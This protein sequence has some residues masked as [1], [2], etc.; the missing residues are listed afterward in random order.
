MTQN[1]F[2]KRLKFLIKDFFKK[3][4][5]N[6]TF[7]NKRISLKKEDY[8]SKP[9]VI[10]KSYIPSIE[11]N[12]NY[13]SSILNYKKNFLDSAFKT[14]FPL[15]LQYQ[16]KT[17]KNDN[18]NH[19][20]D[21]GC[22]YGPMAVAYLNYIKSCTEKN[23]NFKYL[24]IDIN[25]NAIK[26]LKSKYFDKKEYEFLY[27]KTEIER[28]YL[29]S[30]PDQIKTLFDSDGSE[31][32]Y[33]I[34]MNFKHDIQWSMSYF[35]HLTPTSCDKSL[36]L[37]EKNGELNSFQFNSWVIIDDESKF[38]LEARMSKRIAPYDMG[39]YL[40]RS[41]ENPLTIT[42]Y[43]E[44]FIKKIYERNNLKIVDIIKGKWRGLDM[45]NRNANFNQDMI[46]SQKN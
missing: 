37:I 13:N 6:I 9:E 44:E 32:D 12:Y 22:G 4:N 21:L 30:K 38:A 16:S 19:F 10:Y 43:K 11:L 3:N 29:Q 35:T 31:V 41:K 20:L 27:H 36:N 39:V 8:F 33:K 15:I 45:T 25:E 24:G 26:W 18:K 23:M 42:C 46:I 5:Y 28:D 34:P 2:I 40:T 1:I 7:K 14:Y 17:K